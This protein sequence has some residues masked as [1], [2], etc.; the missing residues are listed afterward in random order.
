MTKRMKEALIIINQKPG[1]TAR[2]F[3]EEFFPYEEF[4]ILHD[5]VTNTGNGAC[6]GKKLWLCAGSYLAKL[7]KKKL[8]WYDPK[9]IGWYTTSKGKELL[10]ERP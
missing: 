3:G 9:T 1:I 7:R 4:P 6:S 10:N 2:Q 5:A 8:L